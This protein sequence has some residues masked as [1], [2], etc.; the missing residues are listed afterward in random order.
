[1]NRIRNNTRREPDEP[2]SGAAGLKRSLGPVLLVMF[3]LGNILG[4]GIYVLIGKVAGEAGY[5]AP[6]AFVVAAVVAAFSALSYAELAARFPDAGG[7]VVYL[8]RAFGIRTL[9]LLVGL[10]IALAGIASAA[11]IARGFAGYAQVF[12]AAPAGVIVTLALAALGALAVWGV[13]ESLFIAAV[14][15][16]FEA[17]GLLMVIVPAA[18]AP[19]LWL[20]AAAA[21]STAL[22]GSAAAGVL[23]G[24]FLAFYAFLGFEDMVNLAEEASNPQRDMPRAIVLALLIST[25]FYA[26]TVWAALAYMTP[27]DLNASDAPLADVYERITGNSPLVLTF[28]AMFAVINGALVQVIMVSRLLYGMG[29]RSRILRPLAAVH[30]RTRTPV[31]STVLVT[32]IVAALAV[33]LPVRTLAEYTSGLVLVVF[34]LVNC[35]LIAVKR[36]APAAAGVRVVPRW[37]PFLGAASSISLLLY[38]WWNKSLVS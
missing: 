37:V 33:S 35:S 2:M 29:K 16:A 36:A 11:A 10:V 3:G 19:G 32:L 25:V 21:G 6:V 20:D 22:E 12:W 13:R 8:D 4:A 28:I 23:M 31:R 15:T 34:V 18:D 27:A 26:F 5:L 17:A 38:V 1:M 24:A 30:P 7:E 9:S 14:L